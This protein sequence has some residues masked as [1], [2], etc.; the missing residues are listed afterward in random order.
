MS[1]PRETLKEAVYTRN[2][3]LLALELPIPNDD[4]LGWFPPEEREKMAAAR[5]E[6]ARIAQAKDDQYVEEAYGG[7]TD[8]PG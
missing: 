8:K 2:D 7:L 5:K 4:H 6:K 1:G 3:A